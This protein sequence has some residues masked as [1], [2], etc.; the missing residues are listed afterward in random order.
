MALASNAAASTLEKLVSPS[1][2]RPDEFW[3]NF[4][5]RFRITESF[6]SNADCISVICFISGIDSCKTYSD[7]LQQCRHDDSLKRIL[8]LSL[9][10]EGDRAIPFIMSLRENCS[11][12]SLICG[13]II[14]LCS[15]VY[16]LTPISKLK[17]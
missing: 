17:T 10:R 2:H 4:V 14:P 9:I 13:H 8:S 6:T 1:G 7:R 12:Y 5:G 15:F 3:L 11:I 16:K